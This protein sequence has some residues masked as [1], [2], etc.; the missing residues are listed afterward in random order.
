MIWPVAVALTVAAPS[1]GLF[2]T[3]GRLAAPGF[4]DREAA[5]RR[6]LTAGPRSVAPLTLAAK[7]PDAEVRRRATALLARL[8]A[9]RLGTPTLVSLHAD[10]RRTADVVA[11]LARQSGYPLVFSTT[12]PSPCTG[13][14]CRSGR[15]WTPCATRPG[16]RPR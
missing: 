6:L 11:D 7:S 3:V 9:D 13:S 8:E 1:A 10:G 4:H 12:R 16:W 15:P 14:G 5:A 2:V